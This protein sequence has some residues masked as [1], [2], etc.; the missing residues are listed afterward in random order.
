MKRL[1]AG[2]ACAVLMLLPR[3]PCADDHCGD[4]TNRALS[5]ESTA[6]SA[7][8]FTTTVTFPIWPAW[9]C[10]S[11]ATDEPKAVPQLPQKRCS[12]A[13]A[14]PQLGQAVASR[15]PQF[16]QNFW[17]GAAWMP[18]FEQFTSPASV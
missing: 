10:A 16:A 3:V 6:R 8:Q 5:G 2:A 4:G 15:V 11:T 9:A 12:S 17:P 13:T 1:I 7:F 18:Q 14:A